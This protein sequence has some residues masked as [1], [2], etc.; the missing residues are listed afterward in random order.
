M[1]H[2][3]EEAE[4]LCSRIG[5]MVRGQLRALGSKQHL[6][7]KFGQ[8]YEVTI[9]LK[10]NAKSMEVDTDKLTRFLQ[11]VFP[12]VHLL[13]NNAGMLVYLVPREEL[14]IGIAFSAL[15]EHQN[16]LNIEDYSISQP[17]LEQV[18]IRT[19]LDNEPKSRAKGPSRQSIA[20]GF[21]TEIDPDE[22]EEVYLGER[23][24]CSCLPWHLQYLCYFFLLAFVAL[25]LG[26]LAASTQG[27]MKGRR[28][29]S[30]TIAIAII[31]L[32]TSIVTCCMRTC[33]CCKP[34]GGLEEGQ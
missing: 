4:A 23:N 30:I 11:G 8:G 28:S 24:C 25:F 5:I 20:I 16:E 26:G 29:G 18:F 14:K 15:H 27:G 32:I 22:I 17:T 31:C 21:D 2:S 19:V 13:G 6:K 7:T 12:S 33:P 3:M 10:S 1:Q 9:K 34:A